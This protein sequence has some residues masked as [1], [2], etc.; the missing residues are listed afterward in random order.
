MS[1]TRRSAIMGKP[2]ALPSCILRR[3]ARPERGFLALCQTAG[4]LEIKPPT[5]R[6]RS[7]HNAR[8]SQ[9]E[10]GP[11]ALLVFLARSARTCIV[12]AHFFSPTHNLLHSLGFPTA[13][14]A[15]LFQFSALLSLEGFLKIIH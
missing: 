14:H 9:P 6:Q 1:L 4:K 13:R 12:A 11:V 8:S 5:A 2:P 3:K 7:R 15:R 10:L